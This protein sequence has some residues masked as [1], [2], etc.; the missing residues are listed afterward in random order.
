MS[1]IAIENI[2]GVLETRL[3]LLKLKHGY[4]ARGNNNTR[5][6]AATLVIP[7]ATLD[8]TEIGYRI[9]TKY[10]PTTSVFIFLLPL[11]SVTTR[12]LV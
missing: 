1:G 8:E 3:C 5:L 6:G 4:C 12:W 10:T 7:T 2:M 11:R 9:H